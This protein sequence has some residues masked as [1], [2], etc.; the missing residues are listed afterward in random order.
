MSKAIA[1]WGWVRALCVVL[2]L[3]IVAV[4]SFLH[5]SGRHGAAKTASPASPAA[6]PARARIQASYAALPLAFEKNDGQTDSQ[7]KYMARG[8]GYV[9]FLTGSDAVFSLSSRS[10]ENTGA[11]TRRGSV[12]AA[13][14]P[15]KHSADSS[16]VFRMQLSGANSPA[17]IFASGQLPGKSNYFFGNDPGKWHTDVPHYSRVSYQGVYPGIDLAFH[18]AQRQTEFDFVVAPGANPAPIGLH[19]TG[20][21]S[22]TT[23]NAGNLVIA[24]AAGDIQLHKP[25]AYQEQNGIREAVDARFALKANHQVSFELGNY[26][27]S[28][29]LVIDPTFSYA[30][31]TYLGGS[32]DDSGQG[33]A[34]DS[35][36]AAYV[37]GQTASPNFPGASNALAD[38]ASAFVTKI[39]AD[40]SSQAYS[41][42]IG[43]TG[44]GAD[45]GNSIAVDASGNAFVTGGTSST[46]FPA[47]SGA[48]Q[49]S[50]H[51]TTGNAFV[52]ELDSSGSITY[53]TYLGG[54]G[55][56]TAFGIALATDNSGDVY[57][58]GRTS[59]TNFPTLN[60]F[61]LHLTGAVSSGFVTK[62]NSSGTALVYSTY[63]GGGTATGDFDG[64]NGVAVDASGNAYI[65]G[66]TF[67]STYPT[68][69]GA[70]QTTCGSCSGGNSNAFVTVVKPAGNALV[71]STFLGGSGT[72]DGTSI[73]VDSSGN[74]YVTGS[75][76]SSNFPHT[77]GSFGG[78]TDAFV[79]KLNAA[80][81]SDSY[82]IFLGGTGV[83]AGAGIALDGSAN[84][85]VTG[86]T[87]SSGASPFPTVN[88]TQ[89]T[90][91]GGGASDA[92]VAEVSSSGSLV[93]STY[94]GGSGQD[95]GANL[96]AI[97]VDSAGANIYV[98]GN[99]TQS[100]GTPNNFPTTAS[101][102]QSSSGGGLDGFVVKYTQ[103]SAA[104]FS[105][106]AT[107]LTPSSVDPGG[108][109]TS[110]VTVTAGGGFSGTVT[111]SCAVAGPAGAAHLPTCA[112]AT[113]A[114]GTPG[115]LTV[116]TTAAIASLQHP[117]NRPS[118]GMLYAMFLPIGGIAL[119]G[120]GSK[121]AR[122]K[123]LF[124]F[125]LIGLVLSGF[126]LMPACGG[127]SSHNTGGGSP[128][129]TAG[130]YSISVTGTATGAIETGSPAPL[131]L[132]VN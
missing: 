120:L 50:L 10:T 100:P 74:A 132:T 91:F 110:T 97:A 68:T 86:E 22:L 117:A 129:T 93:F 90:G 19:F 28:R 82:S 124:G 105:L 32:G 62:V 83:D 79:T 29:E 131:N 46:N 66:Q 11:I 65:T 71:Y 126:I 5:F 118:S 77:T 85:Y 49:T 101:P 60:A 51:G 89:S 73:A 107:A 48:F 98:T 127:S 56:D 67:S 38:T 9:L 76:T 57:V 52:L 54:T 35:S 45:S 88:P 42:Y 96:G 53:S 39:A 17:K 69:S 41:V 58:A 24:S 12:A 7:V 84:A 40:G 15:A 109:A 26:D 81:S 128:G 33:I 106:A 59:S 64:A 130:P 112:A 119:L 30:Y 115:T 34:F 47:T 23:D 95:D 87:S 116:N 18:G 103:G 72:D 55:T 92:F 25:V 31:S 63:L 6:A 123:K 104:T 121:D 111:L 36:G 13:K 21:K 75:T 16:A 37:T 8:N 125:L 80:G 3:A 4:G 2:V 70:F 43:G 27:R 113:A 20:A 94:L 108:S 99:T 114:P 78:S 122:R 61:Q 44:S 1:S 14:N 102:L